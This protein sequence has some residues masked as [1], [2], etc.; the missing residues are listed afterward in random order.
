MAEPKNPPPSDPSKSPKPDP[1][2]GPP[3][4][5]V[6]G[7]RPPGEKLRSEHGSGGCGKGKP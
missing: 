5:V 6:K 1:P 4:D 7:G 3:I 2:K